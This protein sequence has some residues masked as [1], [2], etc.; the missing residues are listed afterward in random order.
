MWAE[1]YFHK[2]ESLSQLR[3]RNPAHPEGV[4]GTW[5]SGHWGGRGVM[6]GIR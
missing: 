5:A 1:A 3:L 4:L 2:D 6:G